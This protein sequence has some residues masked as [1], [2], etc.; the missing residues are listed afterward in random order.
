MADTDNTRTYKSI[1]SM[2]YELTENEGAF[3]G[4]EVVSTR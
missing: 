2:Q 1:G 3:T 4:S